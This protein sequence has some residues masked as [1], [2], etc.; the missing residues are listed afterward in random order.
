MA[1]CGIIRLAYGEMFIKPYETQIIPDLYRW[2]WRDLAVFKPYLKWNYQWNAGRLQ[3]SCRCEYFLRIFYASNSWSSKNRGKQQ[4]WCKNVREK[5]S[6]RPFWYLKESCIPSTPTGLIAW[7]I[8]M[9]C[10]HCE[11]LQRGQR[12]LGSVAPVGCMC[13]GFGV[14]TC[15][16]CR[17]LPI[18]GFQTHLHPTPFL[19]LS[20]LSW[21]SEH[22][23][24]AWPRS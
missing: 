22:P 5:I 1:S 18:L 9:A 24:G 6:A 7:K 8:N 23:Q 4:Q 13:L 19:L 2:I 17:S 14:P 11:A 21:R 15:T 10:C 12:L 20:M 16:N 3:K